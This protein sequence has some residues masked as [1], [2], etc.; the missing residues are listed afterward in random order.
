MT[1]NKQA[2]VILA[3]LAAIAVAHRHA[4]RIT[5]VQANDARWYGLGGSKD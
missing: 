5:T 1:R 2:T 3:R 4:A